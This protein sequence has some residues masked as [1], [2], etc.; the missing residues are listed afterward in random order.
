MVLHDFKVRVSPLTLGG[1]RVYAFVF[2]DITSAKWRDMHEKMFVHDLNNILSGLI[3]W[4]EELLN[5]TSVG[6][7]TR[8]VELAN[9]LGE[10]LVGHRALMQCEA[11]ELQLAWDSIDFV[12]LVASLQTL[13]GGTD[14]E[15]KRELVTEQQPNLAT[16][17]TDRQLLG[18]VLGNLVKNALEATERGGTVTLRISGDTE[19]T[20]FWIHNHSVM[21]TEVA[22]SLFHRRVS[23]KGPGRGLGMYAVQV[24]GEQCLGGQISFQSTEELGTEFRFSL[25]NS[26]TSAE[27]P[28]KVH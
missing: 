5:E 16:L 11:G 21:P 20:T 27:P 18:R 28:T 3:G 25:P 1:E 19:R 24:L 22:S 17:V 15:R 10:H 9:H 7:A 26:P 12:A 8:I 23:T 14:P 2:Q 13:F 6:A 4:S